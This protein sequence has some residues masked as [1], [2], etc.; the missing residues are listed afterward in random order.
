MNLPSDL[1]TDCFFLNH[2]L[3]G[4][5]KKQW[6]DLPFGKTILLANDKGIPLEDWKPCILHQDHT[7]K[8]QQDFNKRDQSKHPVFLVVPLESDVKLQFPLWEKEM[9]QYILVTKTIKVG[10]I[11]VVHYLSWHCSGPPIPQVSGCCLR[12]HI[13]NGM[14]LTDLNSDTVMYL[15]VDQEWARVNLDEEEWAEVKKALDEGPEDEGLEVVLGPEEFGMEQP[16]KK[17][18]SA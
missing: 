18:R 16:S 6:P 4:W 13:A 9:N 11:L 15:N 14:K 2:L 3:G 12:V 1:K 8:M 5:V 7:L 17:R 10:E